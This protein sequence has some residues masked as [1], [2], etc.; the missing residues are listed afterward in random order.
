MPL[1]PALA[2]STGVIDTRSWNFLALANGFRRLPENRA[3]NMRWSRP[4]AAASRRPDKGRGRGQRPSPSNWRVRKPFCLH[5]GSVE[6]WP[7]HGVKV[8]GDWALCVSRRARPRY[9]AP[10]SGRADPRDR[11]GSIRRDRASDGGC[12]FSHGLLMLLPL[13]SDRSQESVTPCS[14]SPTVNASPCP[15]LSAA[16]N[17]SLVP[18]GHYEAPPEMLSQA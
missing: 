9:T 11:T 5:A 4:R 10:G 14:I 1:P 6:K 2:I 15:I 3:L 13:S 8:D 17:S 16:A 7:I 12:G 18:K